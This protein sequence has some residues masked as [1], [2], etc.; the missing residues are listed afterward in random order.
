MSAR[1]PIERRL[2]TILA[3]LSAGPY[4]DYTDALLART[5]SARQRPGWVFAERWLPVSTLT[6]ATAT[7]PRFPW[8]LVAIVALL[9]VALA[10]GAVLIAS[11]RPQSLPAPFGPAAN[12]LI[13]YSSGGDIFTVDPVTNDARAIVS[14]PDVDSDPVWSPDG[15]QIVFRRA[16]QVEAGGQEGAAAT[17]QVMRADGSDAKQITPQP[18]PKGVQQYSFSPDGREVIF[19]GT[20]TGMGDLYIAKTDGGGVR[21][22]HVGMAAANPSYRPPDGQEIVFNGSPTGD[23]ADVG[24]YRVKTDG[25]SLLTLIEPSRTAAGVT[26]SWSP[27]GTRI[28]YSTVDFTTGWGWLRT[29]TMM[30]DGSAQ[31]PLPT[32]NGVYWDYLGG[33]SNDGTRL[34]VIRGYSPGGTGQIAAAVV[35]AEGND[36][37][38]ETGSQSL[39]SNN[40]WPSWAPDDASILI[41]GTNWTP[42]P[43]S[44][45]FMDPIT[46]VIRSAPFAPS[47]PAWQRLAPKGS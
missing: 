36:A 12:G 45:L 4:P 32:S 6:S 2:P 25:D 11:P 34:V 19:V 27:D 28:A 18:M 30:A 31:R 17:L 16:A 5:A 13:A 8:R 35:P 41:L 7:L 46:G 10:V 33:W 21:P 14:G 20:G 43:D 44:A 22:L 9:I 42:E 1:P 23:E 47:T 40:A 39:I 24:M 15:T 26:P 37:G 38:I 3:D 29:H